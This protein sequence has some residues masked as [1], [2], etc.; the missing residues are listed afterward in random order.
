MPADPEEARLTHLH[1]TASHCGATLELHT[2]VMA[3]P[4]CGEL[5]EVVV[6]RPQ[7]SAAQ[8]KALWSERRR[9][10]ADVDASGVWRFRE[11]LPQYSAETVVTLREGNVPMVRAQRAA[12]FAGVP[13]LH[14]KHLGWNP[15]GCFK[16]LGMTTGMTEA[17]YLS[18]KVVACASTGNTAASLAAYAARA[19]VTGRVYLPAGQVS[20]NKLA[21]AL[22]FG[23]EIVEV[24]GSFDD[25]LNTLLALPPEE[26]YFLNSVNPFRIE[27]QKTCMYEV[28]EERGWRAPDYLVVP[29][30]NLGNSAS[31]GKAFD[32]L[33]RWGLMERAPRLIVVQAAG[34]NPF[35]RLWREREENQDAVMKPLDPE[36]RATAIR[37]GNPRSW[38]KALHGVES[39]GGCVIDVTDE[40]IGAAKA[41]I[42]RDG[43]GCEPASATTLAGLKK[44][45]EAGVIDRD[46]EVV[47]MLT[48]HGLKDTAYILEQHGA[49]GQ[50][51]QEGH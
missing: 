6:D 37:I 32:E 36:T 23:A 19:G 48:G 30:G 42:G 4:K 10:F 40:E 29:G 33:L 45:R 35:A 44:L 31:F 49:R 16:D 28:M 9:S 34:A 3:C 41:A 11:A 46:A 17:R 18:A 12:E 25:A 21:Q 26:V 22:D 7:A 1:C 5:L 27:G 13:H 24:A 2:P 14:F 51:Q 15:T 38:R 20:M 8:L 39:T 50:G 43:I 47:A